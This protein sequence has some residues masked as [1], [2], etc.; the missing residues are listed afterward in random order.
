M[1]NLIKIT[2]SENTYGFLIGALLVSIPLRY[3]YSSVLLII[4]LAVAL[5]SSF[6]HKKEMHKGYLVS[7]ALFF[8]MVLSLLWTE[9]FGKSLRGLER[10]LPFLIIPLAFW[11]MPKL[12]KSVLH[13]SLF[14]FSAGLSVLALASVI[15]ATVSYGTSGNLDVFFYHDLLLFLDLNAIYISVMVSL[16]LLYMLFYRKRTI[17]NNV[18]G[19]TLLIFLVLLSSKNIIIVTVIAG[20]VG[21]LI[22]RRLTRKKWAILALIGAVLFTILYYSPLK[23]RWNTEFSTDISDTLTCDGFSAVYPWTGTTFRLFQTRIFYESFQENEV[24]FTGF[25]I[26]AAQDRIA[27]KQKE[28]FLYYGYNQYNYHNQ[29]VQAFAEL[30][31]L[32]FV[33][34]ILF[35]L[36]LARSYLQHKE[37]MILFF[38]LIMASVFLTETYIWRQRGMIHFLTLYCLLI[39]LF[40]TDK[41]ISKVT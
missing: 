21:F 38:I 8:L 29:Y 22:S 32:G 23:E 4:L 33:L 41:I 40:P 28:Y 31:L 1:K 24:W 7:W 35:F 20:F 11:L 15:I 10:Q 30:G 2:L 13:S 14:I 25:G 6:Y 37:L 39:H 16:S 27:E 18:I 12:S 26:N 5:L 34:I 3:A 9:N 19:A 36:M 17:W